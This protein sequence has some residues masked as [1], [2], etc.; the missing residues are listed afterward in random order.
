MRFR[1]KMTLCMAG[2][3]SVLFGTG[4]SILLQVSFSHALE[5]E[6]EEA[7]RVYQMT[8]GM[9][10]MVGSI[11]G[12]LIYE[13]IAETVSRVEK[14]NAEVWDMLRVCSGERVIYE[15][16]DAGVDFESGNPGENECLL[17]Y[18]SSGEKE[19]LCL[20]G[21][22]TTDREP[23]R[24]ELAF[25]VSD[26]FE[27]RQ[28]WR[29]IY[30]WVFLLILALAA[31]LSY[32][33]SGILTRPLYVLSETASEIAGGDLSRRAEI[34]T[35]DEIRDLA[36]EFNRMADH[37]ENMIGRLKE[38]NESKERFIDS[39]SHELKTPVTSILGYAD[40]IRGGDLEKEEQMAAADYIVKEARRLER[41][42][43]KLLDLAV[44]KNRD[45]CRNRISPGSVI[46]EI[47]EPM[48]PV[49]EKKNI[50]LILDL[51]EGGCM[52][53]PDLLCLLVRN[54]VENSLHA[55]P[56]AGGRIWVRLRMTRCG[57]RILVCDDGRGIPE[58]SMKHLTEAFYRVDRS[59]S[60]KAGGAGIGL[61]LC[62]EIVEIHGGTIRFRSREGTGTAVLAVLKGGRCG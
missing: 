54:L 62:R 27:R 61:A 28:N 40:L 53:D 31:L 10:R 37:L 25:D 57:C 15:S 14:Q 60:R 18:G 36:G 29:M 52:A 12:D 20:T 11:N 26:T 7:F 8:S 42:S 56:E 17:C 24:L 47:L 46:R 1:I 41:L 9:L 38:E 23:V 39:F 30:H 51:A 22:L 55:L 35:E 48:V 50:R 59:R 6:E 33:F 21:R 32:G 5:Q 16:G 44:L 2:L 49:Y 34:H 43:M 13:D 45:F 19:M 4:G 58:H 3:L